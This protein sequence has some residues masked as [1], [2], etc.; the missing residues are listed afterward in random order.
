VEWRSGYTAG[1][2]TVTMG[3]GGPWAPP[4]RLTSSSRLAKLRK[5]LKIMTLWRLY[6]YETLLERLAQD[7]QDMAAELGELIQ[8]EH[9][10]MGQR[11]LA[12]HQHVAP[13]DQPRIRDGVV[14]RATRAGHDHRRAVA[15]QARDAV[16]TH[17]VEGVG[18]GSDPAE[19][20]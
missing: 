19:C 17:G 4:E 11:H 20:P 13:T 8:E 9:A 2:G 5:S 1:A 6:S 12:R 10:M 18:E 16:D 14:V 15:P 3:M 7:L